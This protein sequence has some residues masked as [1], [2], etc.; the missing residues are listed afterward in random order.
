MEDAR[1]VRGG[2]FFPSGPATMKIRGAGQNSVF[3]TGGL[4]LYY[5][6]VL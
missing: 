5:S 1:D 6:M 2:A 4:D 3:V